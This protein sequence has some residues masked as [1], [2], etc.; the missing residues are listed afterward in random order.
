ME[1]VSPEHWKDYEL[2]DSGNF[3]KLE[4]F[5]AYTLIRP[6]PQA[7][8]NRV[9][10]EEEWNRLA[11]AKFVRDTSKKNNRDTNSEQ[12]GWSF[13][14]KL[15]ASWNIKYNHAGLNIK[16]K[17][18][19]TSFGHIGVFPEQAS[20]WDFIYDSINKI[21]TTIAE[22]KVLNMFAYTGGASLA[23]KAAG[24][25]VTHVDAVRNV[26]TWANDNM[27]LSGLNNIRWLV[28]DALKFARREA[29]RGKF[30]EGIILDPPA[31]GRGPEGEKWVLE[32]QLSELMQSCAAI[33]AK[34]G[35]LILNLYS[36][37]LSSLVANNL[38]RSFFPGAVTSFGESFIL[39]KSG[40]QLPLGV[41]VRIEPKL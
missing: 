34:N 8:W 29:K 13:K 23:A 37:G 24:A 9:M 30:Y 18:Q 16:F 40:Q 4:R 17:L 20:N 3:E 15:P 38:I 25:D 11:D 36:M 27:Q 32:E 12:G 5:G 21:K 7:L 14:A 2:I 26:V 19:W 6:E 31:Y 35:F 28:E 33:L 1:L 39:S 10:K 22:P 41:Y